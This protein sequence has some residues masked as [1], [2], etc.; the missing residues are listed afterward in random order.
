MLYMAEKG[1]GE[2]DRHDVASVWKLL[3]GNTGSDGEGCLLEL[4]SWSKS[5]KLAFS[6]IPAT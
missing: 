2:R 1:A 6:K 3:V 4:I 5:L